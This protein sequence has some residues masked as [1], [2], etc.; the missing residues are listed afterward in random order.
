MLAFNNKA[1]VR[2][3]M[4]SRDGKQDASAGHGRVSQLSFLHFVRFF[5]S[6]HKIVPYDTRDRNIFL[7]S[8][9]LILMEKPGTH[10]LVLFFLSL[11][12]L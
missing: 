8:V 2:A 1:L 6:Q 9:G 10:G 3:R 5:L 4:Q 11:S 7:L 12:R